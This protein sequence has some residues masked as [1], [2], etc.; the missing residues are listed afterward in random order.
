MDM[1]AAVNSVLRDMKMRKLITET[2][3]DNV[4]MYLETLWACGWEERGRELTAHNKR[5][6]ERR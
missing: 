2:N 5:K 6:I 1:D 4:K 3:S